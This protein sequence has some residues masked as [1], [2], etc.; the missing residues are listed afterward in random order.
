[1][2]LGTVLREARWHLLQSPDILASSDSA[3]PYL[4]MYRQKRAHMSPKDRSKNVYSSISHDGCKMDMT[5]KLI[6]SRHAELHT[7]I[8]YDKCT[9]QHGHSEAWRW[10][11]EARK[12]GL[13]RTCRSML[14]SSRRQKLVG[15]SAIW[16]TGHPQEQGES[17][18]KKGP[19]LSGLCPMFPRGK[20]PGQ[21]IRLVLIPQAAF[22]EF[23]NFFCRFGCLLF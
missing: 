15:G 12:T 3:A 6:K 10:E 22:L 18:G 9:R 17:N 8:A 14:H 21:C 20:E 13:R 19:F 5:Q 2:R 4:G 16:N 23:G 11:Q 7:A 1:M